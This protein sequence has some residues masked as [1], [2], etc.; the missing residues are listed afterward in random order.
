MVRVIWKCEN[1]GETFNSRP[2]LCTNCGMPA[3]KS[4]VIQIEELD[5]EQM[6]GS[7]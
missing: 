1:C 5:D 4:I 3:Y 7:D 2:A 6:G